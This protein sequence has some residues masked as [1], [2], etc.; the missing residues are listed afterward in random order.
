MSDNEVYATYPVSLI[1]T[2]QPCL[3]VGGG[4]VAA[5]KIT[6]LLRAG[7]DV[8]VIAPEIDPA[9]EALGNAGRVAIKRRAY[10]AGD[11]AAFHYVITATGVRSVDTQVS[12]DAQAAGVW[13]NSADDPTNCTAMLPAIYRDGPVSIAVSTGGAAPALSIWLRDQ[14]ERVISDRVGEL[15]LLLSAARDE[16]HAQGRST[17]P[18][19]WMALLDGDLPE[20]V[21]LGRIDEAKALIAQRLAPGA[22]DGHH[23]TH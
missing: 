2:D 18:I 17:E 10:Q 9:I 21:N 3:V 7:A 15:A 19:D 6:G 16:L 4:R 11:T 12:H 20:L 14:I 1:M 23:A 13:V 5:R 8:T 22:T